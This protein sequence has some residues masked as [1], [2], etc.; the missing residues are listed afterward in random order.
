MKYEDALNELQVLIQAI[1]EDEVSID[2][3]VQKVQRAKELLQ[4]CQAKL[5]D[6]GTEMEELLAD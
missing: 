5:R 4:F 2:D 3:L 6:I 1:E